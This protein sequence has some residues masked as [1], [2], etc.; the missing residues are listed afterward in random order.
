MNQH[1]TGRSL[2]EGQTPVGTVPSAPTSHI[3]GRWEGQTEWGA[4]S[5]VG[6]SPGR[7][8]RHHHLLCPA[9]STGVG[10]LGGAAWGVKA[11]Q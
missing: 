10:G 7:A 9:V 11:W 3:G 5:R 1:Q 8:G 2:L 6:K 4:E